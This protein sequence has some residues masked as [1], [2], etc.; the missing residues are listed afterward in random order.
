MFGDLCS[1]CSD[2]KCKWTP[3]TRHVNINNTGAFEL[4]PNTNN[5]NTKYNEADRHVFGV[6]GGE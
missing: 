4:R 5:T 6:Q 3:A 1:L 2:G